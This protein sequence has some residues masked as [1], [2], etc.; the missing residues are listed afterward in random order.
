[1]VGY[2]KALPTYL[3]DFYHYLLNYPQEKPGNVD[4]SFY[5][6]RV[7]F[8]LKP[9][10]RVVH[11][12]TMR[13][14]PSDPVAYAIAEKQLYS[15]HYFETALD[16]TFCVRDASDPKQPGF[17]LIMVMGSEQAGLTGAKGSIVRKAALGRSVSNLQ[18]G[19]ATIKNTLE[20]GR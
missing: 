3:P 20:A 16:L 8:G 10:L 14:S 15:S 5:W 11:V 18:S 19:L 13:G 9:T 7:K 4:N 12:L 6:A 1:M 17:Y 2:S